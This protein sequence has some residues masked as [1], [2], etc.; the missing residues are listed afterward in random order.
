LQMR[1]RP[2]RRRRMSAAQPEVVR[3]ARG[4]SSQALPACFRHGGYEAEMVSQP[5]FSDPPVVK[6]C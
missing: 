4:T 6:K 2:R 3:L 1:P 5:A